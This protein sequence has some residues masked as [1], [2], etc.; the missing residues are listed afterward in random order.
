MYLMMLLATFLSAIYGYNLSARSDYDRDIAKKKA[1]AV[2]YKF[3]HQHVAVVRAISH[4]M[5]V[6]KIVELPSECAGGESCS[7]DQLKSAYDVSFPLPGAT[8]SGHFLSEENSVPLYSIN[9]DDISKKIAKQIIYYRND[10]YLKN[11]NYY[12]F[13]Q[14]SGFYPIALTTSNLP[15]TLEEKFVKNYATDSLVLG[16]SVFDQDEMASRLFCVDSIR[17]GETEKKDEYGNTIYDENGEPV[18]EEVEVTPLSECDMTRYEHGES[19]S[20]T[21]CKTAGKKILVSYMKMDPRWVDRVTGELGLDFWSALTTQAFNTNIG[22]IRWVNGRE[23]VYDGDPERGKDGWLFV[24]K[25]NYS[26][27]YWPHQEKWNEAN[28]SEDG[29]LLKSFPV[30]LRH[31]TRWNLPN[32]FNSLGEGGK[33]GAFVDQWGKNMCDAENECLFRISEIY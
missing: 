20:G 26:E 30:S 2:I 12:P 5:M 27:A 17:P 8:F 9:G 7:P 15:P 10:T 22:I 21:C 14:E 29:R 32:Y 13:E 28:R 23:K 1:M 33:D 31:M 6:P 24:G 25:T 4:G 11:E 3:N 18:M 19:Y 16:Q